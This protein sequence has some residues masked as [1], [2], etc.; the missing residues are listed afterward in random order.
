MVYLSMTL[1]DLT[2]YVNANVPHII[3][4]MKI[5]K[6]IATYVYHLADICPKKSSLAVIAE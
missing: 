4:G 5:D 2:L 6:Y 3:V 1:V